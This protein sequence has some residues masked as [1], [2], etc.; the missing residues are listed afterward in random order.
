METV[1]REETGNYGIV[2]VREEAGCQRVVSMV[3]NPSPKLR[4]PPWRRWGVIL[5]GSIFDKLLEVRP[6]AGGEIQ[7]TDGIA[8]C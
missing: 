6:G 2:E 1:A 4:H 5:P 7:L 8:R 3:E